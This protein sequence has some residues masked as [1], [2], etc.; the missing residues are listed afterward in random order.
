M[1]DIDEGVVELSDDTIG[2]FFTRLIFPFTIA[3]II[4]RWIVNFVIDL[5]R[6]ILSIIVRAFRLWPVFIFMIFLLIVGAILIEVQ[7]GI[8]QALDLVYDCGIYKI[9]DATL[10]NF[11][12]PLVRIPYEFGV[13]RFNDLNIFLRQCVVQ[14]IEAVKD[15]DDLFTISGFVEALCAYTDFVADCLVKFVSDICSFRIPFVS[16]TLQNLLD[17]FPCFL[18]ATKTLIATGLYFLESSLAGE[19]KFVVFKQLCNEL[20][21]TFDDCIGNLLE[22]VTLEN[23][24]GQLLEFIADNP[25][26]ITLP[27]LGSISTSS[28]LPV[29]F[30]HSESFIPVLTNGLQEIFTC[31]FVFAKNTVIS[32]LTGTIIANECYVCNRLNFC[33]SPDNGFPWYVPGLFVCKG[34]VE[35]TD[36]GILYGDPSDERAF[37]NILSRKAIIV[38]NR[39]FSKQRFPENT[40]TNILQ[41]TPTQSR[42][43]VVSNEVFTEAKL[44]VNMDCTVSGNI[45]QEVTQ[46]IND[47]DGTQINC[48]P[49]PDPSIFNGNTIVVQTEYT[50]RT[51]DPYDFDDDTRFEFNPGNN[52]FAT[53]GEIAVPDLEDYQFS[54]RLFPVTDFPRVFT[55]RVDSLPLPAQKAVQCEECVNFFGQII[56][57]FF[58]TIELII[59][60][61]IS[62]SNLVL[63]L[64]GQDDLTDAG[65]VMEFLDEFEDL[66]LEDSTRNFCKVGFANLIT[67]KP[68][69][70]A[71]IRAT[72]CDNDSGDIFNDWAFDTFED[73][74]LGCTIAAVNIFIDPDFLT[75]EEFIVDFILA[76][77]DPNLSGLVRVIINMFECGSEG[78]VTD[79][80]DNWENIPTDGNEFNADPN[81]IGSCAGVMAEIEGEIP[82]PFPNAG[83]GGCVGLWVG[84][85][86]DRSVTI[87]A[88]DTFNALSPLFNLFIDVAEDFIDP[89]VCPFIAVIYCVEL[90]CPIPGGEPDRGLKCDRFRL[91]CWLGQDVGPSD[92]ELPGD[93]LFEATFFGSGWLEFIGFIGKS[94]IDLILYLLGIIS[95]FQTV[96]ADIANGNF[97]NT[98][99]CGFSNPASGCSI[100][101]I[102]IGGK[103]VS[104]INGIF[105]NCLPNLLDFSIFEPLEDAIADF[106][107]LGALADELD[108]GRRSI[109]ETPVIHN[110]SLPDYNIGMCNTKITQTQALFGNNNYHIIQSALINYFIHVEKMLIENG[111]VSQSDIWTDE[112]Y[113]M[114]YQTWYEREG[115]GLHGDLNSYICDHYN[116]SGVAEAYYVNDGETRMHIFRV[117]SLS[118]CACGPT[119]ITLESILLNRYIFSVSNA[120]YH[121]CAC[122]M[123]NDHNH[124]TSI[125][126]ADVVVKFFNSLV[127]YD[128]SKTQLD[129]DSP[130]YESLS[131]MLSVDMDENNS[132]KHQKN[133]NTFTWC[134]LGLRIGQM[135]HNY[136]P[137][138]FEVTDLTK[139][140]FHASRKIVL[141]IQELMTVEDG[142][143]SV[144]DRVSDTLRNLGESSHSRKNRRNTEKL[145]TEKIMT[146]SMSIKYDIVSSL[147]GMDIN[148]QS[149]PLYNEKGI[150]KNKAITASSVWKNGKEQYLEKR[151][152]RKQNKRISIISD[153]DVEIAEDELLNKAEY[154]NK[155]IAYSEKISKVVRNF[156][157]GSIKNFRHS[158]LANRLSS[159]VKYKRNLDVLEN[160][161]LS[162][163]QYYKFKYQKRSIDEGLFPNINTVMENN[164]S[165]IP[166]MDLPDTVY[167]HDDHLALAFTS[168]MHD[169]IHGKNSLNQE[170]AQ[171]V[172]KQ[173]NKFYQKYMAR[174]YCAEKQKLIDNRSK[175][176]DF[177]EYMRNNPYVD[178]LISEPI[179]ESN[180]YQETPSD[181]QKSSWITN[182]IGHGVKLFRMTARKEET[183]KEQKMGLLNFLA[184][185]VHEKFIGE[186]NHS[187]LV[188]DIENALRNKGFIITKKK[189]DNPVLAKG[190]IDVDWDKVRKQN[191]TR[192]PNISEEFDKN[193]GYFEDFAE[194][195]QNRYKEKNM[196][197]HMENLS[198]SWQFVV[199]FMDWDKTTPYTATQALGHAIDHGDYGGFRKW[200]QG[201]IHFIEGLGFMEKDVY[202]EYMPLH[203]NQY[204]LNK[205][206]SSKATLMDVY[207]GNVNL[208]SRTH[209][210]GPSIALGNWAHGR[211]LIRQSKQ[212]EQFKQEYENQNPRLVKRSVDDLDSPEEELSLEKKKESRLATYKKKTEK[213]KQHLRSHSYFAG[214][215][216]RQ[217]QAIRE[218]VREGDYK[219]NKTEA[220]EFEKHTHC[221]KYLDASWTFGPR[222]NVYESIEIES[223]LTFFRKMNP[224][225]RIKFCQSLF[226]KLHERAVHTHTHGHMH[227]EIDDENYFYHRYISVEEFKKMHLSRGHE[228]IKGLLRRKVFDAIRKRT[229]R[230]RITG[231]HIQN[232][233]QT[234][235]FSRSKKDFVFPEQSQLRRLT[236]RI[237]VLERTFNVAVFITEPVFVFT[238]N[239]T[240]TL[241]N[242]FLSKTKFNETIGPFRAPDSFEDAFERTVDFIETIPEM[243]SEF[244]DD[245]ITFFEDTFDS[246]LD[247]I[248][249]DIPED[250]DGT[251]KYNIFCLLSGFLPETIFVGIIEPPPTKNIPKQ[252]PWPDVITTRHKNI[253][254]IDEGPEG[255]IFDNDRFNDC[256]RVDI[257]LNGTNRLDPLVK[258]DLP[259]CEQCDDFFDDDDDLT[260]KCN[261]SGPLDVGK[262]RDVEVFTLFPFFGDIIQGNF[263]DVV[264]D[265]N[266]N[267]KI[268]ADNPNIDTPFCNQCDYTPGVYASCRDDFGWD[269]IWDSWLFYVSKL[270]VLFNR[271]FH[272]EGF[273]DIALIFLFVFPIPF[274]LFIPEIDVASFLWVALRTIM[275]TLRLTEIVSTLIQAIPILGSLIALGMRTWVGRYY[276]DH[277]WIVLIV[278]F[279]SVCFEFPFLQENAL[280]KILCDIIVPIKDTKIVCALGLDTSLQF[281]FDRAQ[282]YK[283]PISSPDI[284][285][286]YWTGFQ[287]WI[288]GWFFFAAIILG[289]RITIFA[290]FR[291]FQLLVNINITKIRYNDRL[292][293]R[294]GFNRS[295]RNEALGKELYARTERLVGTVR[296]Q[297]QELAELPENFT[298]PITSELETLRRRH[299]EE[300]EDAEPHFVV[301]GKVLKRHQRHQRKESWVR[302]AT[303]PFRK[304]IAYTIRTLTE[305]QG[306]AHDD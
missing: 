90:S 166:I 22:L 300:Q 214:N 127:K 280:L 38:R 116:V 262:R 107:D 79:C 209:A 244:I 2:V 305:N 62:V 162:S 253:R 297:G 182:V 17:L 72:G 140:A 185:H 86:E 157:V 204:H 283:A 196:K 137:E 64:T 143:A 129:P 211:R 9:I 11:L 155:G 160:R 303:R 61:F 71:I 215:M 238:L 1:A 56:Q 41:L 210:L 51:I 282:R 189:L 123:I 184:S 74:F 134:I 198:K 144:W 203:D 39:R 222:E 277:V 285:C 132:E 94:V 37:E 84:C 3:A 302:W 208:R 124:V 181:E 294:L 221:R 220:I 287:N 274:T 109:F 239:V 191:I 136:N 110:F 32:I 306:H 206:P 130:C 112:E 10:R 126:I 296:Q 15:I 83:L 217:R 146:T 103:I 88:M 68:S 167:D 165:E 98:S 234:G 267:C 269:D 60:L 257:E 224:V 151:E 270:P 18:R 65:Q 75:V 186:K 212:Y 255:M 120:I 145:T 292:A 26:N 264:L 295:L 73:G 152:Q 249:C 290:V 59:N 265:P 219:Y 47:T 193:K 227:V 139:D 121:D 175:N 223:N 170:D 266:S 105:T 252:I 141:F 97:I 117:K 6:K 216:E 225:K 164:Q 158:Q 40:V 42:V 218:V 271:A 299:R 169:W 275:N 230:N 197:N 153:K 174:K 108:F 12:L 148:G 48:D 13:I 150:D 242:A 192:D 43:R 207:K 131:S 16:D 172:L 298:M 251:N 248:I 205:K 284:F 44:F 258:I 199:K 76:Q 23:T 228:Y 80:V 34:A 55:F 27:S 278:W 259:P 268:T 273:T 96:F 7:T 286:F 78:E 66:I 187:E 82:G 161:A 31:T 168:T 194:Y 149:T 200:I 226:E 138:K 237:P 163:Q 304:T 67:F 119:N 178:C 85:I 171:V 30:E 50:R 229:G 246:V 4:L 100:D 25:F 113:M 57:C 95:A 19:F 69:L 125:R 231:K 28:F 89:V 261:S 49:F 154:V 159:L 201:E 177:H 53:I 106:P 46:M 35:V 156:V 233:Y 236:T 235:D 183:S 81:L 99:S 176:Q 63:K 5:G 276:L 128:L 243:V 45:N 281:V 247:V 250:F 279:F 70:Y 52:T 241:A 232:V 14:F 240:F 133:Y 8:Q 173:D 289:I 263:E 213:R 33:G 135:M 54:K 104:G 179:E 293:A 58:N 91:C 29:G 254:I 118:N 288:V 20:V 195:I 87:P 122:E 188:T 102:C 142:S 93:P 147:N 111:M 101:L 92:N 260:S 202:D 291:F 190:Q 114:T 180:E 21:V 245:P 36:V 115:I 301:R 24:I 77:I 256:I 272:P